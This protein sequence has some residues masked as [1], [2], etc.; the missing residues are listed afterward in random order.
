M[1]WQPPHALQPLKRC[2]RCSCG[3]ERV[4]RR[5]AA[6]REVRALQLRYPVSQ[7]L[8]AYETKQRLRIADIGGLPHTIL[9][10]S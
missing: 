8:A 2:M 3:T 7:G 5:G 10:Y 4:L 1:R 9:H 6:A